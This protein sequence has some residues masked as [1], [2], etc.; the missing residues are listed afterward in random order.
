M[1]SSGN[2]VFMRHIYGKPIK[3]KAAEDLVRLNNYM[4]R[5]IYATANVYRRIQ[6]VEDLYEWGNIAYCTPTWDIDG[7]LKNWRE[8]IRIAK[9]ILRFLAERGIKESVYVKWSGNGCHIHIN[10]RSI[11]KGLL[12]KY[13]PL[14]LAY[15]I[16]EYVNTK[17][18]LKLIEIS[19]NG[20]I[21]VENKMD[22][23]RVFTC[24]LSLHRELDAVCICMK[25]HELKYFTPEWINPQKFRHNAD[26]RQFRDEEA[27]R[28]AE[29]AY[30]AVG[31]YQLKPKRR[32]RKTRPLDEQILEW[33]RR[34]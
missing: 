29:A 33:L 7:E 18:S 1:N 26:W 16:V 2:M 3:I 8:T 30:K 24:P 20:K 6:R 22:P 25:P 5:S 4:F 11:S 12:E 17:L 19:S 31:G 28:L 13:N 9:E 10:E 32:K 21:K 23:A 14:D 34:D 15:A 27:D